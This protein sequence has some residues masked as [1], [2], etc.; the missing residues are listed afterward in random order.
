MSVSCSDPTVGSSW[1]VRRIRRSR[2][3]RVAG[4]IECNMGGSALSEPAR[5]VDAATSV[6]FAANLTSQSTELNSECIRRP[7]QSST[8]MPVTASAELPRE[9]VA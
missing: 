2:Q 6:P 4:R 7:I 8:A 9:Y 1:E 3:V 5:I